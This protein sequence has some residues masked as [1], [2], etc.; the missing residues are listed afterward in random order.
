MERINVLVTKSL[1]TASLWSAQQ[2]LQQVEFTAST[3]ILYGS[4]DI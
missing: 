3:M 4:V 1:L 2:V